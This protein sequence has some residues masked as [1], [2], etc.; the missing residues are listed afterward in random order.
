[1]FLAVL[2]ELHIC[3]FAR[4]CGLVIHGPAVCAA[5]MPE[6]CR[7]LLAIS[8]FDMNGRSLHWWHG[9]MRHSLQLSSEKTIACPS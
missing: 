4:F 3:L 5:Q 2:F 9:A 1:M 8:R 7:P 6:G